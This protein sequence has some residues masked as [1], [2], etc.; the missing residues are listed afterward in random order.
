MLLT[1]IGYASTK[2]PWTKP[3]ASDKVEEFSADDQSRAYEI[4]FAAIEDETDWIHGMYWW[5]WPTNLDRGGL[6][7]RGFTPNG[8]PAE[9]VLRRWYGS[10]LQ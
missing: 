2:S 6:E 1:E 3:H 10:R 5:K 4:A 7:H 9:D 8:K